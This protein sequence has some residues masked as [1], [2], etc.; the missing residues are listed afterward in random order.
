MT[1]IDSCPF[2][3]LL[4]H[5]IDT[6]AFQSPMYESDQCYPLGYKQQSF[7]GHDVES[8]SRGGYGYEF[9]SNTQDVPT[10]SHHTTPVEVTGNMAET[11]NEVQFADSDMYG[12]D[13]ALNDD[14]NEM[15]EEENVLGGSDE[16]DDEEY[17]AQAPVQPENAPIPP[18]VEIPYYDNIHMGSDFDIST[19]DVVP[20]NRIWSA[21]NPELDRGI[22][23]GSADQRRKCNGYLDQI[24]AIDQEAID[25]VHK[26]NP[27]D[28]A[29]AYDDG[30]RWGVLT[31]NDAECFNSVLKGAR[32][33]PISAMVEFTFRRLVKYFDEMGAQAET[34]VRNDFQYPREM[35]R[36]M[37]EGITR[38]NT[39]KLISYDRPHRVFELYR[40][41]IWIIPIIFMA[42]VPEEVPLF[43][44][45]H[46]ADSMWDRP[47]EACTVLTCRRADSG[48]WEYPLDHRVLQYL[49]RT[50]F[51]GVYH[52]GHIRLDHALITALVERWRTET[53]TFHFSIGEATV[54]LQDVSVLYGLRIDSRAVTGVDSSRA[55]E[56]WIALCAELLGVAPTP[57]DLQAGRVRV[58]WLAEH[59]AHL[60][61]HAPDELSQN[62]VKLMYLPLLRDI[63]E[64]GQYSWGS[65][66]L[67]WLYRMLCRAAQVGT[68]EIGGP[69]VLLQIWVWERLICIAPSRRQPV[70]PGELPMGEGDMQLPTGPRGINNK[71]KTSNPK[72]S[73]TPNKSPKKITP[74][75]SSS[76][77][78]SKLSSV[79]SGHKLPKTL[80]RT[81]SLKLVRT[82]IKTP[83]F[84]PARA[85]TR[86]C[87][88]A[89]LCE[90][91]QVER[92]TCSSTLKDSKFPNYLD[93][94]PGA[95]ESQGT[96]VMKV[97]PYT[98]CS[99]NGHHHAP[100]P[101]LKC[102]LSARRHMLKTQKRMKK[103][104]C[105]SPRPRR[106]RPSSDTRGGT[107]EIPE[108]ITLDV[109]PSI[110]EELD[111]NSPTIHPLIQE[112]DQMDYFIEI[113]ARDTEDAA[114]T[115][116]GRS[117]QK[118]EDKDETNE[119]AAE[120][121][122]G[123]QVEM[124]SDEAPLHSEIDFEDNLYN[125]SEL[126]STGM[127]AAEEVRSPFSTQ[128]EE[129]SPEYPT[130][131][132]DFKMESP[133][134]TELDETESEICDM[135]WEEGQY[136]APSLNDEVAN[137]TQTNNEYNFSSYSS[138]GANNSSL[139][140][141]PI[142]KSAEIVSSYFD[143]ISGDE[144]PKEFFE[145]EAASSG[146]GCGNSRSVS[147]GSY[148]HL[149]ADKSMQEFN[150]QNYLVS[151]TSDVFKESTIEEKDGNAELY[152]TAITLS[153]I[154]EPIEK[155][156]ALLGNQECDSCHDFTEPGHDETHED[157]SSSD[158][159]I[160]VYQS[161]AVREEAFVGS[162][163]P[164]TE[165]PEMNQSL[166]KELPTADAGDRTEEENEEEEQ[167]G[168]AKS[169]IRIP[170][171]EML[172]GLSED[173][174]DMTKQDDN[175][176]QFGVIAEDGEANQTIVDEGL[177]AET[178]VQSS[179]RESQTNNNVEDQN[180]P[181]HEAQSFKISDS[182]D[183]EDQTHWELN[184]VSVAKNSSED[185]NEMEVQHSTMSDPKESFP[186]SKKAAS[187]QAKIAFFHGRNHSSQKTAQ[188]P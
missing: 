144:G 88:Q 140:D 40:L 14:D 137:S 139:H 183:S 117:K 86:K 17:D 172:Q 174:Q 154:E 43:K 185:D 136:S 13:V 52:I 32:N 26:M 159:N 61:D 8:S 107:K 168:A 28:W 96:S 54:T 131:Q 72:K 116:G 16:D 90:N 24:Q 125:T 81:S 74:N 47:D 108:H 55:T 115:T 58:R 102:F 82:L 156:S 49:L 6:T 97:C 79:S 65:T 80:S 84:K 101:P 2:T 39:F 87:S 162:L 1:H 176:I 92:S 56:Q 85:S 76:S 133:A 130:N 59:F 166:E 77:S 21:E 30:Y 31:S 95:T 45:A 10:C 20:R 142:F 23:A 66:A 132:S 3:T 122:G 42:H 93:L 188:G 73:Q 69:L 114:E 67:A 57:A 111:S 33:L 70:G 148:Q 78:S 158:N 83:S 4:T 127:E 177:P 145:E 11:V 181:D 53:H 155:P 187:K 34:D 63:E 121:D 44:Q 129:E 152:D 147:E 119:T 157:Y 71:K 180:H 22:K 151:S 110:Q 12:P 48:L 37:E 25:W 163:L 104:G 36:T 106:A 123:G 141:E 64:I 173:H 9:D 113:Y 112:D 165:D 5:G 143:D 103:L 105:L 186:L 184:K 15:C 167:E 146:G 118:G 89:V 138:F 100:L 68:R 124:F 175:E 38:G 171:S 18:R 62:L 170:T 149:G 99:L 94:S 46:R 153:P 182:I 178:L 98:Y 169:L 120:H 126:I 109:K 135:E 150:N 27:E 91:L 7:Q 134:S 75:S 179:V 29:L 41:L 161:N 50:G 60:P 128:E 51:Y 19:R 35:Q 164:K 160:E